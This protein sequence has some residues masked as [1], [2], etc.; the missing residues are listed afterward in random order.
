VTSVRV[1]L[2]DDH[3]LVRR[4]VRDLLD[5]EADLDVVGEASTVDQA[6]VRIPLAQPDVA[7]LDVRLPDGDGI[8]VCREVRSRHPDVQCVMLTSFDDDEALFS[9]VM[10]GAAG[11]LM[12]E[13]S[14]VELI[15]GIRRA[16]AGQ[17][18]L[19]PA[20]ASRLLEQMR[21]A[22][23]DE[24]SVLS[25]QERKVLDLVG[26]G[27]TNRQIGERL[28][29]AEKTVRNYVSNL[30]GKLGMRRRAEAAAYA[31]RLSERRRLTGNDRPG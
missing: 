8:A 5:T 9:A 11:Y 22:P 23:T 17:S 10:A 4:G 21:A 16:A 2:L 28:F 19:D 29:L 1:F 14:G 26:D 31:A 30:L 25:A 24:L 20:M 27:L 18:I 3:E 6:L 12:K 7:L 13:V 15:T